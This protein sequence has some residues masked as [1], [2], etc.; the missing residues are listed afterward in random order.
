MPPTLSLSSLEEPDTSRPERLCLHIGT[1]V[2]LASVNLL[3]LFQEGHA[4]DVGQPQPGDLISLFV[5]G[6]CP[7]QDHFV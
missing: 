3:P 1:L 6:G 2:A 4:P 7:D 5:V